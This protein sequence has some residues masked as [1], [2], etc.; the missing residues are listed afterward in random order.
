M[1]QVVALFFSMSAVLVAQ[2]APRQTFEVAS[3]KP[4]P[5]DDGADGHYTTGMPP[6]I[7]AH[8]RRIDWPHVSL[9]GILCQAYGVKPLDI[10]APDWMNQRRY[11]VAAKIPA[12]GPEGHIPEMLQN[13]LADRFQMKQHW[14]T[15]EESGY[16]L[17]VAKG[18]ARLK[19]SAPDAKPGMS[20]RFNGHFEWT[21][22]TTDTL[23]TALRVMMGRTVVNA[24]NLAGAYDIE[25]DA[26]PGS[27]PGFHFADA[28]DSNFPTIFAALRDLGLELVPGKVVVKRLVVD[29]ALKVPVAN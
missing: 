17:T 10:R 6:A 21:A 20:M 25:L 29:S 12:D 24:T 1:R 7:E 3:V 13:L 18:G 19:A 9:I 22:E 14:E 27:M 26:S 28:Q 16:T 8:A 5:E 23:A 4:A 2:D 15:S 11:M